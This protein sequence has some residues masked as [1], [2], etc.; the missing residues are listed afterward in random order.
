MTE[1]TILNKSL[2]NRGKTTVGSLP[3]KYA[4][5]GI[6]GIGC[7]NDIWFSL[8]SYIN[9]T[10]TLTVQNKPFS[11]GTSLK[12]LFIRTGSYLKCQNLTENLNTDSDAIK[13][14]CQIDYILP[15][16]PDKPKHI[17]NEI[18]TRKR[19]HI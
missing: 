1:S 12:V 16:A 18:Q 11:H 13:G 2:L 15:T 10:I 5:G 4:A 14:R 17:E 7:V 6:T 9:N 3:G 8:F 19:S